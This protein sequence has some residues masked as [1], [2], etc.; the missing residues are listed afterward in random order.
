R[1]R[2][3]RGTCWRS[4]CSGSSSRRSRRSGR[5]A[6]RSTSFLGARS[7]GAGRGALALARA[8]P[9]PEGPPDGGG[10]GGRGGGDARH[11]HP[12]PGHRV[13]GEGPREC[14]A[15]QFCTIAPPQ[16]A[17]LAPGTSFLEH[18]KGKREPPRAYSLTSAPHERLVAITIKEEPYVPGTTKYPPLLSPL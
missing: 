6:R 8:C 11:R 5:R 10:G 17:D 3:S 7:N 1:A 18:L 13:T 15:G 9:A 14:G 12:G 4:P 2:S 16:S